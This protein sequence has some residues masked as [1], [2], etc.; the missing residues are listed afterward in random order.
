MIAPLL[1]SLPQDR[2][3]GDSPIQ[4]IT[5][6]DDFGS[7]PE[8]NAGIIEAFRAGILTSC[9]LMAAGEA[10]PQAVE[11]AR[12][13]KG[14]A[15]GLHL[16][17]VM[18]QAVLPPSRISAL[19]DA[20]GG[21]RTDPTAAGLV[22]YFSAKARRQ[23][24]D[25]LEAQIERFLSTGLRLSHID[26]HL[27][28]HVHPVIFGIT[29]ELAER[30][31]VR[32]IR[33]PRDDWRLSLRGDRKDLLARTAQAVVFRR[34]TASMGMTLQQKGFRFPRRVYGHFMSGRMDEAY[35]LTILHH[36]KPGS[37]EMYFHP[38]AA[39]SDPLRNSAHAA[40]ARELETVLS[41]RVAQAIRERG[42]RLIT[43]EDL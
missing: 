17:T 10:F 19:V 2:Q 39:G 14:L 12:I 35:V 24:A 11:A 32:C 15:V 27:H 30:Y 22:Y 21:F 4:L 42:I 41:P 7:S 6:G 20:N 16:V 25:E 8:T 3:P 43:Y 26:S 31:G 5:N 18:G 37:S 38:S 40:G 29:V 33:V 1:P 13:H 34:L 23:L 28:M 36:L 9:S